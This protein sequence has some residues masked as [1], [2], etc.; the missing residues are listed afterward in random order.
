MLR[1]V[2][3]RPGSPLPIHALSWSEWSRNTVSVRASD[4]RILSNSPATKRYSAPMS[5]SDRFT[6]LPATFSARTCPPP[7]ALPGPVLPAISMSCVS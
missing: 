2:S 3:P 7:V 4:S 5:S 1:M 6:S